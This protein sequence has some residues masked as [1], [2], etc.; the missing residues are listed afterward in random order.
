MV[1]AAS[2]AFALAGV[3]T[4]C[5]DS[6]TEPEVVEVEESD[7]RFLRFPPDLRPLVTRAGSFWAVAGEN[8]ELVLR[9]APEDPDDD[10]G[11]E[12]LRFKVSGN[13]LLRRPDGT[14][15]QRGDSVR[16]SVR[17]DE[18]GR[19]LFEFEP[20]G[21]IFDPE[22]PAELKVTYRRLGE[23]LDGDGDSDSDDDELERRMSVWKRERPGDP[24]RRVGTVKFEESKEVEAKI[25]SFTGFCIAA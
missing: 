24:W 21:L 6:S 15:F 14:R 16:I 22:H 23:D 10:E 11:D 19:F 25:E 18:G 2:L 7:L 3:V 12:F 8:R 1:A 17:V 20:T 13:S 5:A 4:A 9:Y